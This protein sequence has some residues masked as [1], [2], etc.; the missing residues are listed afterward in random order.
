M[1][2]PAGWGGDLTSEEGGLFYGCSTLLLADM[3]SEK[4]VVKPRLA[5]VGPC[6]S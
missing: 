4:Q 2:A 5:S 1:T 6:F 3:G